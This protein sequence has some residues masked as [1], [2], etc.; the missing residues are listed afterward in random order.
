MRYVEGATT[1]ETWGLFRKINSLLATWLAKPISGNVRDS[2]A[3]FFAVRRETF[4]SAAT[5]SPLGYKI[6]LELMCKC[7]VQGAVEVPIHFGTRRAGESKLSFK[8]QIA[9]LRHLGRLYGFKFPRASLIGKLMVGGALGGL[10][11]GMTTPALAGVLA[12]WSAVTL[13]YTMRASRESMLPG[14]RTLLL[15]ERVLKTEEIE[16]LEQAA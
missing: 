8:Q 13:M 1:D 12:M 9:Y 3:G 11:A 10:V 16:R 15:A 6:A 7:G 2:M 5:L 4:E 14:R